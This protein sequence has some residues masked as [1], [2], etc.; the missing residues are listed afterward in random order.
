[1]K[2][3]KKQRKFR[4]SNRNSE[5]MQISNKVRLSQM[6]IQ[7][8]VPNGKTEMRCMKV[9]QEDQAP[10]AVVQEGACLGCQS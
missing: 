9:G 5:F 10:R 4:T 7:D 8:A 3:E 1:M 6:H 2:I